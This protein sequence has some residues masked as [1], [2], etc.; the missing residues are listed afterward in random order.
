M[1]N[2][3]GPFEIANIPTRRYSKIIRISPSN[4]TIVG[5]KIIREYPI[6]ITS[7]EFKD[8]EG[9]YIEKVESNR[10][11]YRATLKENQIN[12]V[13]T[14]ISIPSNEFKLLDKVEI[15]IGGMLSDTVYA[16]DFDTLYQTFDIQKGKNIIPFYFSKIGIKPLL[17]HTF[18]I[19]YYFTENVN[20]FD[21]SCKMYKNIT[22]DDEQ[23]FKYYTGSCKL[24]SYEYKRGMG[25]L[26]Q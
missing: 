26:L 16:K 19:C 5:C 20:Y 23:K 2:L 12:N 18:D 15:Y 3:S 22:N 8:D 11:K 10:K 1:Y 7:E 17:Y 13:F 9:F 21:T 25:F 4:I 14:D 24:S 6:E